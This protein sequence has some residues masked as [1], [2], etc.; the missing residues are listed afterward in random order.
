MNRLR[1]SIAP[2]AA[3]GLVFSGMIALSS[4]PASANHIG[5]GAVITQSTTLHN[6]VGPCSTGNGLIV[7]GSNITL[8]LG[9]HRVFSDA[10]L[11]RMTATGDPANPFLP[12]DVTGILLDNVTNVTVTNGTVHGFSAGV[13]IDFG[14]NN[15]INRITA[16]DNQGACIG[17][18]FT[19]QAVGNYGDGIV[20]FSST[21]N[22]IEN[23]QIL[24]NGPFSGVSIV[25]NVHLINR[26]VGPAPTGNVVRGNNIDQNTG[27]FADIGVRIE[28]PAASNNVVSGNRVSRS[29]QEGISI[30]SVNNIDIRGLIAN[31]PTCQLR[32]FA[33]FPPV[34]APNLPECPGYTGAEM[35]IPN[36]NNIV[37]GNHV[38]NNGFGGAQNAPRGNVQPVSLQSASGIGAISFC[39]GS[40]AIGAH[41][42]HGTGNVIRGNASVGNAGNGIWVGG[43][44]AQTAPFSPTVGFTETQIL[45]NVAIRNNARGCGVALPAP[46][47]CGGRPNTPNFD[48]LDTSGVTTCPSTAGGVQAICATLGFAAP[49]AAPAQF[50]GTRVV[51]PGGAACDNNFW[52]GNV[53]STAF[54]PCTTNGGRQIGALN[55]AP[56]ARDFLSATAAEDVPTTGTSSPVSRRTAAMV[57]RGHRAP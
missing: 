56:T 27:C 18:D 13:V 14:G 50:L 55:P 32:G 1:R 22:R 8:N 12:T 11:P 24:R 34:P 9:G 4:T 38:S 21:N 3:L 51:I 19:T 53:Y 37:S 52:F 45:N 29:F 48:L 46:P 6:D 23:N 2:L 39:V 43:C 35:S 54:P 7:R 36:S 41:A 28:G 26:L 33:G 10:P 47:G 30:N 57:Q 15:R 31:P 49:P 5:C 16:R 40:Q 20:L 44:P 25:A 17:E 42:V